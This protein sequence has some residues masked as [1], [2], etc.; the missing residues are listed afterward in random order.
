MIKVL[1]YNVGE[2][3]LH[4]YTDNGNTA[5][6]LISDDGL[7]IAVITKNFDKL[8]KNLAYIDGNNCPWARKFLFENG[9]ATMTDCCIASGY[10][11]YWMVKLNLGKIK[12][13][14]RRARKEIKNV[15]RNR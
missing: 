4:K 13:Y 15:Y 7:T 10:C 11:V 5:I 14:N 2:I 8:E 9:F 12:S 1:G 6:E 3:S